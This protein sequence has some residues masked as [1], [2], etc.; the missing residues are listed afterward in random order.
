MN[1]ADLIQRIRARAPEGTPLLLPPPVFTEMNAEPISFEG[2]RLVVRFPVEE[3][4]L[5]PVGLL[6]GGVVAALV[7]NTLGP[8]SYLVAPPSV[9]VQMSLTYMRP[10]S[11]KS[12]PVDVE[13]YVVARSRTLLHLAADVRDARGRLCASATCSCQILP[14]RS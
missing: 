3:R 7:D 10:I 12:G 5:N 8:L 4:Y 13:G 11:P 2:E 1:A 14:S 6:Q 9:T